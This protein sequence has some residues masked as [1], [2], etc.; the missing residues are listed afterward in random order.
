MSSRGGWVLLGSHLKLVAL[1]VITIS[2]LQ[3]IGSVGRRVP[4]GAPDTML[5]G[6]QLARTW[7]GVAGRDPLGCWDGIPH[8]VLQL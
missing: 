6:P 8:P 3:Q 1:S 7:I 5:K 4:F 2:P